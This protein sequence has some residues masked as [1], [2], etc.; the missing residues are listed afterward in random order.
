MSVPNPATKPTFSDLTSTSVMV[1]F[2]DPF[3][4]G[5]SAITGRQIGYGT[6][7]SSVQHTVSSDKSTLIS[8]LTVGTQY[9]FWARVGNAEGFGGWSPRADLITARIPDQPGP[10]VVSEISQVSMKVVMAEN[11][12]GGSPILQ[13]QVIRNTSN[14]IG[15][16]TTTDYN[17]L[18]GITLTGLL[19][20]TTYYL[21]SRVRNSAG[22][23]PYSP[24]VV[25]KT[26]AGAY[27]KVGAVYKQAVP[28][29][30]DGGVW[31]KARP[32]SRV[33]GVWRETL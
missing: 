6:H 32:W 31:K 28:W 7:P 11:G 17:N 2:N 13:R 27:V 20:A 30:K 9:Y 8:G 3:Y 16:G 33:A 26:I 4:N 18:A 25:A 15:G 21:W 5:G 24:L 14:D 23:S 29:V 1:Y 12:N 19:P 10:L 22:W